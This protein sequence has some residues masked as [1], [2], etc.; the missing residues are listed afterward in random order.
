MAAP[1]PSGGCPAWVLANDGEVGYYRA[2]YGGAELEKLMAVS[3]EKLTVAERVGLLRDL[4]A[5]AMAGAFRL[6]AAMALAPRLWTT[7]AAGRPGRVRIAAIP[8]KVL[9]DLRPY[10]RYVSKTR[11]GTRHWTPG[12]RLP[13]RSTSCE[14]GRRARARRSGRLALAWLDPVGGGA[15]MVTASSRR[16]EPRGPRSSTPVRR[17]PAKSAATRYASSAPSAPSRPRDPEDAMSSPSRVA[18][19]REAGIYTA[20]RRRG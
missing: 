2:L 8:A 16:G 3:G 13:T 18:D 1:S 7:G 9:P 4:D 17:H 6:G 19:S 20:R 5:L 10:R 12:E 11:R 14:G 15:E